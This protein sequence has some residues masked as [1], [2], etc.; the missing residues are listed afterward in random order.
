MTDF[1]SKEE[2]LKLLQ[3]LEFISTDLAVIRT[4]A[5]LFDLIGKQVKLEEEDPNSYSASQSISTTGIPYS[6]RL[7]SATIFHAANT[8]KKMAAKEKVDSESYNEALH[9]FEYIKQRNT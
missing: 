2:E 8:L 9:V 3:G 1:L 5:D 4:M 7:K 6:R